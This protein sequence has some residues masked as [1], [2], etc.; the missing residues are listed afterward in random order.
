DAEGL[1]VSAVL[2][3]DQETIGTL[4]ECVSALQRVADSPLSPAFD[5]R[6]RELSRNKEALSPAEAAEYAALV[7]VWRI[8]AAEKLEAMAALPRLRSKLPDLFDSP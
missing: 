4:K 6:L 7:D 1:A 2:T 8:R 5:E 3:A